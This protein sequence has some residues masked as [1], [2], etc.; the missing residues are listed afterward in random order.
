[1]IERILQ[2]KP[3]LIRDSETLKQLE[4]QNIYNKDKS[5]ENVPL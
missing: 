5:Y 3:D 2:Y 1:M 4:I